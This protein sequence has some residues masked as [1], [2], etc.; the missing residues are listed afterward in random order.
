MNKTIIGQFVSFRALYF[1]SSLQDPAHLIQP[2]QANV[3]SLIGYQKKWELTAG[4]KNEKIIEANEKEIESMVDS[5]G[6]LFQLYSVL[7]QCHKLLIGRK[8][9]LSRTSHGASVSS[10]SCEFRPP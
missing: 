2:K 9:W 10:S 3:C 4:F 8:V 6:Y 7:G 1:Q 5:E